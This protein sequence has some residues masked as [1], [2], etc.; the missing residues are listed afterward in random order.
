MPTA[1]HGR[2]AALALL[3]IVTAAYSSEHL[4]PAF[5][6][7]VASDESRYISSGTEL[8]DRGRSEP[9]AYAPLLG[10]LYGVIYLFLH[11]SPHWFVHA[12]ATGHLIIFCVFWLGL[13]RCVRA[14]TPGIDPIFAM[15]LACA[16]LVAARFF[17]RWNSSDYLFMAMA[18]LAL[19]QLPAYRSGRAAGHLAWGSA[20][21]GLSALVRND[22]LILCLSFLLLSAW[23]VRGGG[24]TSP[25]TAQGKH[26]A[27]ASVP[28]ALIVGGYVASF[29]AST[30]H[31]TYT[32]FEYGQLVTFQERYP[33]SSHAAARASALEDVRAQ[34][35]TRTENKSSVFRAIAGNP[36]AFLERVARSLQRLPRLVYAAHG[37]PLSV[38]FLLLA[39][40]GVV[41][42]LRGS[43]GGCWPP[44]SCGMRISP[45]TG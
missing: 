42:L 34:F 14:L 36:G 30:M 23:L 29:G 26:F 24:R 17:E 22:G 45:P 16:W 27:A 28:L 18:A 20:F 12:A 4:L 33:Q 44:R 40:R 25:W 41:V 39:A 3:A 1:K 32:A 31:R 8:V 9:L 2:A 19:S 6:A 5:E 35:G 43:N 13:Y 11:D 7:I 37:R 15:T 38:I 21:A 10:V